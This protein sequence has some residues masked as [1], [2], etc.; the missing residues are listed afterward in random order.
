MS[1]SLAA[2]R[3]PRIEASIR[4]PNDRVWRL[5]VV[6][7]KET[8]SPVL[9]VLGM[10]AALS[11]ISFASGAAAVSN[12]KNSPCMQDAAYRRLDFWL[13]EWNVVDAWGAT[14]GTPRLRGSWVAVR[15]GM[16]GEIPMAVR[17]WRFFSTFHPRK[18]GIRF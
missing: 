5:L 17:R 1:T 16:N 6:L 2:T 14:V 10:C 3:R 12:G 13:G 7:L 9:L 4:F 8:I 11:C 15:S 18:S